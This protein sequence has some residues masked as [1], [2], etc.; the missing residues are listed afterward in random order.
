MYERYSD[1]EVLMFSPKKY[2][3]IR[4]GVLKQNGISA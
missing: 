2:I 3:L 4:T 1:E